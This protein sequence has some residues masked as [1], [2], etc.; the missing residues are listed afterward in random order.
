MNVYQ[1]QARE[2]RA[3]AVADYLVA[4]TKGRTA[5]EALEGFDEGGLSGFPWR[6]VI[7]AAVKA[8]AIKSFPSDLDDCVARVRA[9]LERRVRIEANVQ[10]LFDEGEDPL[11]GLPR[12]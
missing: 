12:A 1:E 9:R 8:G 11:R 10:R 6:V 7:Q 2:A 3:Q 4:G 5:A